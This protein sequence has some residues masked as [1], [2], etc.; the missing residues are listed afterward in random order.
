MSSNS[1]AGYSQS[2]YI[3][4]DE[5]S[6][7]ANTSLSGN[8][9]LP[10]STSHAQSRHRVDYSVKGQAFEDTQFDGTETNEESLQHNEVNILRDY[11]SGSQ[12]RRNNYSQDTQVINFDDDVISMDIE[13]NST[14]KSK[15]DY[16]NT[17]APG[18]LQTQRNDNGTIPTQ[19]SF[20]ALADTQIIRGEQTASLERPMS[21]ESNDLKD[22]QVIQDDFRSMFE[23]L[24]DTQP[25][26]NDSRSRYN[27]LA[28]TQIIIRRRHQ[29][30]PDTQV[31]DN[32]THLPNV[33]S[34]ESLDILR[35]MSDKHKDGVTRNQEADKHRKSLYSI[36]PDTQVITKPRNGP[37][38]EANV[39]TE[40]T[41]SPFI[42]D[43]SQSYQVELNNMQQV[44]HRQVIN[45]QDELDTSL[46]LSKPNTLE[47]QTDEEKDVSDVKEESNDVVV[48]DDTKVDIDQESIRQK[49][50]ISH[51]PV[52]IKRSKTANIE[53]YGDGYRTQ[54]LVTTPGD[55]TRLRNHSEP[56]VFASPFDKT[57]STSSSS[58]SKR[59]A[60]QSVRTDEDQTQADATA[61]ESGEI[62]GEVEVEEEESKSDVRS[63]LDNVSSRHI[64]PPSSPNGLNTMSLSE[65]EADEDEDDGDGD[66]DYTNTENDNYGEVSV[67][68]KTTSDER[69]I[70]PK[71]RV[72][73]IVDSQTSSCDNI[74]PQDDEYTIAGVLRKEKSSVLYE[75][76]IVATNSVWAT[77]NLK[78]YSGYVSAKYGDFSIVEFDQDSSRIKNEDLNPLDIRIGDTLNVRSKRFKCVVTGL[79]SAESLSGIRCIRGYNLVHVKRNSKQRKGAD[80]AEFMVAVS[81]CSMELG[82]W[83]IHQQKFRIERRNNGDGEGAAAANEILSTPV[84][85]SMHPTTSG[86]VNSTY[87]STPSK[88]SRHSTMSHPLSPSPKKGVVQNSKLFANRL[89]CITNIDGPRK[90][91]LKTMIESNGGTYLDSNLMEIFQYMRSTQSGGRLY[92]KSSYS[93]TSELQFA[94]LISNSYCRSSKYLQA[95]ALGWPLLS[96]CY[97]DDVINGVADLEQW[98]VYCLPAGQ[99]TILNTVMNCDVF[100]FRK[101]HE[102][103][104]CL[105]FQ[106]DLNNDLLTSYNVIVMSSGSVKELDKRSIIEMDTCKFIFHAFGARSLNFAELNIEG[107]DHDGVADDT[108]GNFLNMVKKLHGESNGD[109]LI[110]DYGSNKIAEQLLSLGNGATSFRENSKRSY[111]RGRKPKRQH[112]NDSIGLKVVDWEWVVQCVISR[113]IWQPAVTI[114]INV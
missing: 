65:S 109:I 58:P 82:D 42:D 91:T 70:V 106:M 16:P 114:K 68:E 7:D 35:E 72:N 93:I 57:F 89:F 31:I 10:M 101:N 2:V 99:S 44:S 29:N 98:P 13:G 39:T 105:D 32:D 75:D 52:K 97:I 40:N 6:F 20:S 53:K 36:L 30:L 1:R 38:D 74:L 90:H 67:A 37:L 41:R 33:E 48:L 21:Q 113:H 102:L 17:D 56:L 103:G 50:R 71:R 43:N 18:Q 107:A 100:K 81:Q 83:I 24:R 45:T 8:D 104:K 80:G 22:T 27:D 49:R 34:F 51:S 96:E 76:E 25:I 12:L 9:L 87:P 95:L 28:E 3:P 86:V 73:N 88:L 46:F 108:Y 60:D 4:H 69:K 59:V 66:A 110:C 112:E 11:S 19:L 61:E 15:V 26:K 23:N 62:K 94:G 84:T 63:I 47:V 5:D 54:N 111:S 64:S 78:M 85:M 77:Y 14:Q 92:L 55:R 79:S